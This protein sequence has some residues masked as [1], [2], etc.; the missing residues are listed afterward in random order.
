M[1]LKLRPPAGELPFEPRICQSLISK[2]GID[3]PHE[4]EHL[5]FRKNRC[6]ELLQRPCKVG[7]AQVKKDGTDLRIILTFGNSASLEMHPA[8]I[9]I[10][11]GHTKDAEH[12]FFQFFGDLAAP[13]LPLLDILG[14]KIRV[15]RLQ[16]IGDPLFEGIAQFLA[17][18]P[19]PA[20]KDFHTSFLSC[21]RSRRVPPVYC[22][23]IRSYS[24]W[25]HGQSPAW[26]QPGLL[27]PL[28]RRPAVPAGR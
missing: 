1:F 22:I 8:A 9:E 11:R 15:Y 5:F 6:L 2:L 4:L 17:Q 27:F 19:G 14:G 28:A 16:H 10:L 12:G 26:M 21:G 25:N 7:G 3:G 18:L 23:T 13:A 20:D 24:A